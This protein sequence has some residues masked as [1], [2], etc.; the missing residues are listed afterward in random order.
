MICEQTAAIL[1]RKS[2]FAACFN[3]EKPSS[4]KTS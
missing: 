2:I 1:I 3:S 4:Q